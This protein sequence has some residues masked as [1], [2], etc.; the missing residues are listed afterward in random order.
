[1]RQMFQELLFFAWFLP[2]VRGERIF[3][4]GGFTRSHTHVYGGVKYSCNDAKLFHIFVVDL[5]SAS[6]TYLAHKQAHRYAA[7][8]SRPPQRP[9]TPF[10]VSFCL[11]R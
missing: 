5:P 9:T 11:T 7:H 4:L 6:Q 1:M 3:A 2:E 10:S 8:A